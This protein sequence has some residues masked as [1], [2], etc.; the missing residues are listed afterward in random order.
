MAAL[1]AAGGDPSTRSLRSLAQDDRGAGLRGRFG[2]VHAVIPPTS[3]R[4]NR[5]G[6]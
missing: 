2:I 5:E 1:S 3:E 4:K 6:D